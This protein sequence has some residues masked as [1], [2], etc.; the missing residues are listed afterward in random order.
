MSIHTESSQAELEAFRRATEIELRWQDERAQRQRAFE[1]FHG[2]D[3]VAP[4]E[5]DDDE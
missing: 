1:L 2:D 5:L 3:A 4:L